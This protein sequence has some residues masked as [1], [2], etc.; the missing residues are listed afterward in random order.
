MNLSECIPVV[1]PEIQEERIFRLP[2]PRTHVPT[3]YVMDQ[4]HM[5]TY[6]ML[7]VR[8][9]PPQARS[10]F[11]GSAQDA[12]PNS[13]SPGTVL[14]DGGL[15]LF[16]PI[17]P[18]FIVVGLIAEVESKHFCPLEDLAEA[19]A[20]LHAG[21]RAQILA[22]DL[23][24]QHSDLWPDIV[25]FLL[26]DWVASHLERVCDTQDDPSIGSVIY[27]LNW[28]KVFDE[29]QAKLA[30]LTSCSLLDSAPETIGRQVRKKVANVHTATQSEWQEAQTQVAYDTIQGYVAPWITER[31]RNTTKSSE[32]IKR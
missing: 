12:A 27:R 3:Y 17:D 19:A 18:F 8:P 6:E 14:K 32:K 2:H 31:W 21:R 7:V 30:R 5:R 29:L 9:E 15:R 10:W 4:S 25:P 20:D 13:T 16:S 22:K 23:D 24:P 28:E 1:H 11:V 26:Q